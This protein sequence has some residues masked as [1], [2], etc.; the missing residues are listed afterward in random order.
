[1]GIVEVLGRCLE[2]LELPDQ[3]PLRRR[4]RG[5]TL[6]LFHGDP[7]PTNSWTGHIVEETG[8]SFNHKRASQ[9]TQIACSGS[10]RD[11]GDRSARLRKGSKAAERPDTQSDA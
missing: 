4:G 8:R 6:R 9:A 10:V 7:S 5:R 1:M 2:R 11:G 3:E